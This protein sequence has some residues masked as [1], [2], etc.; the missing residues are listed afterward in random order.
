M[1]G[2]AKTML[3]MHKD[4]DIDESAVDEV[5]CDR[6]TGLVGSWKVH[7]CLISSANVGS[8]WTKTSLILRLWLLMQSINIKS[9]TL[10]NSLERLT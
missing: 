3:K 8:L 7:E 5:L 1:F 10:P 4:P 2:D 6:V 9:A